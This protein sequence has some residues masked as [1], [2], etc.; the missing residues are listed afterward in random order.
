MPE[1]SEM[2]ESIFTQQH[3]SDILLTIITGLEEIYGDPMEE[4]PRV[5]DAVDIDALINLVS[6]DVA[7]T[8]QASFEYQDVTVVVNGQTVEIY[9]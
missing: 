1:F 8:V 2:N 4:L 6:D 7:K 5:G 3:N 9:R